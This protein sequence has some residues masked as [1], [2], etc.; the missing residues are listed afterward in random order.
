[1]L[2]GEPLRVRNVG[3]YIGSDNQKI[4]PQARQ[5]SAV[6][7]LPRVSFACKHPILLQP[8]TITGSPITHHQQDREMLAFKDPRLVHSAGA[9]L[10][11]LACIMNCDPE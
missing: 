8:L 2:S 9:N 1:M 7:Q 11:G 6:L 5:N 10:A 3:F 4:S